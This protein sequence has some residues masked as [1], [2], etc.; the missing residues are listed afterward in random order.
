MIMTQIE[1]LIL[2]SLEHEMG[3]VQVYENAVSCALAPELK[4][5]WQRYL[6]QTRSACRSSSCVVER[7]R[8][9]R[10]E[11]NPRA[12]RRATR[13]QSIGRSDEDGSCS[14]KS[15]GGSAGCL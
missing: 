3:G 7:A 2:Q 4:Q 9:G 5:E 10:D 13:R 6:E 1:E 12:K 15:G 11:R 8:S 14:R